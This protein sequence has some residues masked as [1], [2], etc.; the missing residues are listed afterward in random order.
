[1]DS[2]VACSSTSCAPKESPGPGAAGASG[3]AEDTLGS[4]SSSLTDLP[5][6]EECSGTSRRP[7]ADSEEDGF[8]YNEDDTE[9]QEVWWL[10]CFT[11]FWFC[12]PLAVLLLLHEG[13]KDPT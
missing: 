7:A 12:A 6:D 11:R 10:C 8:S 3:Q 5:A 1:M 9:S 4:A 13:L 2:F